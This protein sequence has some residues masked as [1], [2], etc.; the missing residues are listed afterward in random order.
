MGKPEEAR[1]RRRWYDNND[2]ISI[3]E[4]GCE[5]VILIHVAQD[6]V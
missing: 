4:I 3:K 2:E 5:D 6:R 1:L